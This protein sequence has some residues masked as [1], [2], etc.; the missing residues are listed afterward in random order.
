MLDP[1]CCF[2]KSVHWL[3]NFEK[4]Y[5]TTNV[6]IYTG[7][8]WAI[9]WLTVV[10]CCSATVQAYN[11][12][13]VVL[14]VSSVNSDL[15]RFSMTSVCAICLGIFIPELLP[16]RF[17]S[18]VICSLLSLVCWN[19]Y[20]QNEEKFLTKQHRFTGLNCV[21]VTALSVS[22][23]FKMFILL[24]DPQGFHGY[25]CVIDLCFFHQLMQTTMIHITVIYHGAI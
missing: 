12:C 18:N 11:G 10:C 14:C 9:H 8:M 19:L 15:L 7:L 16:V 4:C 17:R 20:T 2:M 13:L 1:V 25:V 23:H 3:L 22:Q 21:P 5:I 24:T 6:C